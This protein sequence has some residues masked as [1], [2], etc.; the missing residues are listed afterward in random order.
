MLL[1]HIFVEL[2][3]LLTALSL[4]IVSYS[5]AP[6]KST[7]CQRIRNKAVQNTLRGPLKLYIYQNECQIGLVC[8][9][10]CVCVCLCVYKC[11]LMCNQLTFCQCLWF[12]FE[13]LTPTC[14]KV[15]IWVNSML[16]G[17][18]KTAQKLHKRLTKNH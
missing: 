12:N 18:L 1:L 2:R 11:V 4:S 6:S 8:V 9:C 16:L 7:L 15:I 14:Y 5:I 17:I 3:K 10:V 13:R